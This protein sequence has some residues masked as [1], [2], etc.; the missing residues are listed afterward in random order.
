M[1]W[2]KGTQSREGP[3]DQRRVLDAMLA[4]SHTQILA[5]V[6]DEASLDSRTIG[7]LAFNGALLGGTLAAKTFLGYYWWTPLIVVALATG[8]CLWSVFK[9]TSAFGPPALEFYKEFGAQGP[10][11]ARTQLLSDLADTFDFNAGRVKWKTWRLRAAVTSLVVG[12]GVAALLI[13]VVRPTTIR[14]CPREQIRVQVQGH[15]S[16]CLP[17]QGFRL[18]APGA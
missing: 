16:L 9:K 6:M 1:L 5:Q 8:P 12:L 7:L 15:Q 14:A 17:R 10:L 3:A 2:K 11:R 13:T 4:L 18:S